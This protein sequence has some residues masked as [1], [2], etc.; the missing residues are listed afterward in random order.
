MPILSVVPIMRGAG[1]SGLMRRPR[2]G[3]RGPLDGAG[4]LVTSATSWTLQ[5]SCVGVVPS[6]V[7]ISSTVVVGHN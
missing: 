7:L 5:G 1:T 2:E 3:I 4:H 6:V